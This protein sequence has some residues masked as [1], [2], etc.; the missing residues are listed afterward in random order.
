MIRK[1]ESDMRDLLAECDMNI[2]EGEVN[3]FGSYDEGV[4][5]A[6]LWILG[7]GPMPYIGRED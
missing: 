4:R 1:E 6:I 2:C 5:D 3:S 7:E